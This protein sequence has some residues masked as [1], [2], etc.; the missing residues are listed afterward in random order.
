MALSV[1]SLR[2]AAKPIFEAD[3]HAKTETEKALTWSVI[4]R[5]VAGRAGGLQAEATQGYCLAVRARSPMMDV[6]L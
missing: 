1:P 6:H 2:E 4:Y 5:A 3:R